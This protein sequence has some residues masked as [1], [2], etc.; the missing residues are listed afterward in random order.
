MIVLPQPAEAAALTGRHSAGDEI[1]STRGFRADRAAEGTE[2]ETDGSTG[3]RF[4]LKSASASW[5][6]LERRRALALR[7]RSL[8]SNSASRS[9]AER[10]RWSFVLKVLQQKTMLV[11]LLRCDE[12][13]LVTSLSDLA[14]E[15]LNR[16]GY[17][18]KEQRHRGFR[19]ISESSITYSSA[20]S[21]P[22]RRA[23]TAPPPGSFGSV[24]SAPGPVSAVASTGWCGISRTGRRSSL[25]PRTSHLLPA[26]LGQRMLASR[27]NSDGEGQG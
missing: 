14:D 3:C 1:G 2:S 25:I 18:S 23:R 8:T 27:L 26:L 22:G 21:P 6:A 4:G 15:G 16:P 17:S 11:S 7:A 13:M 5:R 20:Q 9:V 19:F 24:R 10:A 12:R